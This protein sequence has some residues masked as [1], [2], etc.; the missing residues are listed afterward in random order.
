VPFNG[1][2]A[3]PILEAK[4]EPQPIVHEVK[5]I[6]EERLALQE[7]KLALQKEKLA[8]QKEKLALQEEKLALQEEK[9]AVAPT[10]KASEANEPLLQENPGRFVLFP[11][12]YHEVSLRASVLPPPLPVS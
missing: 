12:K 6:Q 3:T 1:E 4:S 10:I 5:K 11:I 7:E 8:L 9:L 2:V